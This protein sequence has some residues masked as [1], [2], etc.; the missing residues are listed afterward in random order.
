MKKDYHFW[1]NWLEYELLLTGKSHILSFSIQGIVSQG[2]DL[3]YKNALLGNS[4]VEANRNVISISK[5][6][7]ILHFECK[8][9]GN[10]Y[11]TYFIHQ[12]WEQLDQILL[13]I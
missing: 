12:K 4:Q 8:S 11:L 7:L 2:R 3:I 5:T 10:V 9:A 13:L 6:G 1:L